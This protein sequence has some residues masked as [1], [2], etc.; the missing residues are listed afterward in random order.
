MKKM[1]VS[2]EN[3]HNRMKVQKLPNQAF[4]KTYKSKEVGSFDGNILY[5]I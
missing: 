4:L 5:Y 3:D 2:N 1:A